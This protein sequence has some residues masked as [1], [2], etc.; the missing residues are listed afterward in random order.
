VC[1]R[2]NECEDEYRRLFAADFRRTDTYK[3]GRN[4]QVRRHRRKQKGEPSVYAVWF[5]SPQ[6]V[7][8]GFTTDTN[9]SIFV[10]T[11]R[12]RATRRDWSTDDSRCIWKQPGDL[13][14]EAWIQSTLAFRWQPAF[15]QRSMK[16]CEW[17]QVPGLT[18]AA[19]IGA[20]DEVHG[21]VPADMIG[22]VPDGLSTAGQSIPGAQL[23]MF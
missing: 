2:H 23:P 22:S 7:K 4:E 17:F 13:R 21:L 11:A 6:I 19:I 18:E 5:P 10:C 16:I 15:V 9:D 12:T 14:T 20:L 1:G 8:V 3:V